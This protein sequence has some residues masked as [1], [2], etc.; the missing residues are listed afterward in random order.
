MC[1]LDESIKKVNDVFVRLSEQEIKDI[2]E[3]V[4][5]D[6]RDEE[7][8]SITE[9][10]VM[11]GMRNFSKNEKL[12]VF[13]ELNKIRHGAIN[14]SE[15][16]RQV[17]KVLEESGQRHSA[18]IEDVKDAMEDHRSNG[19]ELFIA[20]GKICEILKGCGLDY[21]N[22][23]KEA[24]VKSQKITVNVEPAAMAKKHN[25]DFDKAVKSGEME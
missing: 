14:T 22:V 2:F 24:A 16:I 1:K 11:E 9:L 18:I 13:S 20:A 15:L 23:L 10:G 17:S 4:M 19:R 3:F 5:D 25:D 8:A 21:V 12:Q 7:S 6:N